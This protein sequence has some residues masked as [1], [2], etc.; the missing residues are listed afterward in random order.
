MNASFLG[1][2]RGSTGSSNDPG[3]PLFFFFI[4]ACHSQ[5]ARD[6]GRR[7]KPDRQPEPIAAPVPLMKGGGRAGRAGSAGADAGTSASLRLG[8]A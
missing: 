5:F 4:M 8:V 1:P 7:P 2:S 6:N 3:Q